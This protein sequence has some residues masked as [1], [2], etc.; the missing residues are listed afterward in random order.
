MKYHIFTKC[1]GNYISNG[2][3]CILCGKNAGFLFNRFS[4]E[5]QKYF[6]FSLYNLDN[7]KYSKVLE[8]YFAKHISC[9]NGLTEEEYIIK[10][11][12]E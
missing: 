12:L 8:H 7:V 4:K 11:L 5:M 1:A 10:E 3:N 2:D 6:T 9:E